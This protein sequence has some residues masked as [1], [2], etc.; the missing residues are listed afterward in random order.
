MRYWRLS[1]HHGGIFQSCSPL[2]AR[3]DIRDT[4]PNWLWSRAAAMQLQVSIWSQKL[5]RGRETVM[6]IQRYILCAIAEPLASHSYSDRA[7]SI[8]TRNTV[9][10]LWSKGNWWGTEQ[11]GVAQT[12]FCW[13]ALQSSVNPH[14]ID[15][16]QVQGHDALP[17]SQRML[18]C[19]VSTARSLY[20]MWAIM[21]VCADFCHIPFAVMIYGIL[22]TR[23][24]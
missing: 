8:R 7:P 2:P 24:T 19:G 12:F 22:Q 1:F 23:G 20:H 4:Q 5:Y 18:E 21:V 16:L 6:W 17:W 15:Y 3:I 10:L 11:S 14:K 9:L 13:G